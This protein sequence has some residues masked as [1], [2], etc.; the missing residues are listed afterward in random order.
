MIIMAFIFQVTYV[1]VY[2]DALNKQVND[3]TAK[4]TIKDDSETVI[5]FEEESEDSEQLAELED[6]VEVTVLEKF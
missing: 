2:A 4:V 5:L 1:P 6:D 3:I